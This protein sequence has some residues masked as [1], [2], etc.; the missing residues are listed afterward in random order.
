MATAR[1]NDTGDVLP[2]PT[3]ELLQGSVMSLY[4]ISYS[5]LIAGLSVMAPSEDPDQAEVEQESSSDNKCLVCEQ[6]K[7]NAYP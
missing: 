3:N 6:F 1:T 2:T 5:T 7:D 4:N